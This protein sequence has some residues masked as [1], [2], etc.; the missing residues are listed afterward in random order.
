MRRVVGRP[1][2][3]GTGSTRSPTCSARSPRRPVRRQG[4]TRRDLGTP[5]TASTPRRPHARSSPAADEVAQGTAKITDD[6]DVLLAFYDYP[7]EHW[8]HL[9]TTNPRVDLRHRPTPP[10]GHQGTRLPR[11]RHRHGLQAHRI[12]TSPLA[13]GQRTSHGRP[14]PRWRRVR[15]RPARR[16]TRRI[17]RRSASRVTS[18]GHETGRHVGQRDFRSGSA[19]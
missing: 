15:E 14:G 13:S 16:T 18:G 17:R 8:I 19:A 6:L 3:S 4:R 11:R 10:A 12:C 9:R 1:A 5:K 2:I 7:T